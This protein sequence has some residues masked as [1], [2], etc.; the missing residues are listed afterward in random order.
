[1]SSVLELFDVSSWYA[2]AVGSP[3]GSSKCIVESV[4]MMMLCIE[5]ILA[6]G[7]L[8]AKACVGGEEDGPEA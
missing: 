3:V 5:W 2:E 8:V 7:A 1:M 6:L 4:M